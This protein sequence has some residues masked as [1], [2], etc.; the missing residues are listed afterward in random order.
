MIPLDFQ[1]TYLS[2]D[3]QSRSFGIGFTDSYEIFLTNL[4]TPLYSNLFVILP[5]GE[6]VEYTNTDPNDG[7]CT[8]FIP[9]LS[10]DPAYDGST[11]IY[12]GGG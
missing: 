7:C 11:L 3:S 6:E 1:R 4:G 9:T 5:D 10:S 2:Q 8:P 12:N